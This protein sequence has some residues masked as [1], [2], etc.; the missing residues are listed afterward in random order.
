MAPVPRAFLCTFFYRGE[1]IAILYDPGVFPALLNSI[2]SS[3]KIEVN[4]I[5]EALLFTLNLLFVNIYLQR[6][7]GGVPQEGN[8][9][10]HLY[11]YRRVVEELVPDKNNT[12]LVIIDFESWR[13]G[14]FG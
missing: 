14:M 7:N 13:F 4:P 1:K 8:L 3:S 5:T 12:G 2:T 11:V 9:T 10:E 6:R